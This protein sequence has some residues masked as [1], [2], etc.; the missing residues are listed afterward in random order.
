MSGREKRFD[1]N[2]GNV[3]SKQPVC[4][5]DN[6][7]IKKLKFDKGLVVRDTGAFENMKNSS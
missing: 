4:I 1:V 7:Q 3:S 2:F 5:F 6:D